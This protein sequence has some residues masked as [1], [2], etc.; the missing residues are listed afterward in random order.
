M[1]N[2]NT[3]FWLPCLAALRLGDMLVV[4]QLDRSG[5]SMRHVIAVVE[6]LRGKAIRFRSIRD[7]AIDTTGVSGSRS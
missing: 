2:R 3:K 1:A 4:G 5:R 7:G 6:D